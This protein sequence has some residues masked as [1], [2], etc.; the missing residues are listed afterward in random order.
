VKPHRFVLIACCAALPLVA[1]AAAEAPLVKFSG[2]DSGKTEEFG[3]KAPWLL[4]WQV[5]SEFPDLAATVIRLEGTSEQAGGIVAEVAGEGR[6]LK[7]FRESGRY[8][9]D[10]AAQNAK[11]RIEITEIGEEW[12]TRLEQMTSGAAGGISR[13]RAQKSQVI[14]DSFSGWRAESDQSLVLIGTGP[15]SF[16]ISFGAD[17]CPGLAGA[18][19]LS[20]VAPEKGNHDVYDS[21]LLDDGTRCYFDEVA[22]ISR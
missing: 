4:D 21:I 5:E 15:M 13:A 22:W 17:G 7:L 18:E 12:A 1:S 9:I 2:N 16:R 20:F 8:R 14:A 10:V 6:G 11:W 19:A 3:V